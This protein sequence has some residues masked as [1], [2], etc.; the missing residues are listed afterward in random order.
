MTEKTDEEILKETCAISTHKKGNKGCAYPPISLWIERVK[1][2]M[3]KARAAERERMGIEECGLCY[4]SG[5]SDGYANS[6]K[7][8]RAAVIQELREWITKKEN[9]YFSLAGISKY[10]MEE[11]LTEMEA[12]K[13][14]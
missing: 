13:D 1:I 9:S 6:A 10:K 3:Q 7:E 2:A 5:H 8:T 4:Q 14:V 11:K 12:K